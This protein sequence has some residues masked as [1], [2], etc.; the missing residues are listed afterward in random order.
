MSGQG[1]ITTFFFLLPKFYRKARGFLWNQSCLLMMLV[2][3]AFPLLARGQELAGT[4]TG[5]V[6]DPSGAV[7]PHATITI[8]LNGVSSASRIVQTNESGNYTATNL[9]AG[10]YTITIS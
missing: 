8:T 3:L 5:T 2:L 7:I 10:T 1:F 9:S 6:T 4:F